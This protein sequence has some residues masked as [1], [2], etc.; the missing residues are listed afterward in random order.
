ME[1]VN[2]SNMAGL[3]GFNQL[4]DYCFDRNGVI[5]CVWVHVYEVNFSKVFYSK[6]LDEG[7]TWTTAE[8][9]SLNTAKRISEPHIVCDTNNHLHLCYDFDTGN[10]NE[11]LVYY[12]T[13]NETGWSTPDIVSENMPG[14]DHNRIVMDNNNRLYC[15]WFYGLIYYRYLENDSWSDI[16]IL[17]TGS[18]ELFYLQRCVADSFENL[19]C[20]GQHID[21]E[22][23]SETRIIYFKNEAGTWSDFTTLNNA[24]SGVSDIAL[25]NTNQPHADW[26][27]YTSNTYPPNDG[28]LYSYF[29][30]MNWTTP[31]IIVEDP[32]E[33]QIIVDENNSTNIF[34]VEKTDE[35]SMLVHYFKK[36]GTWEGFI[37]DESEWYGMTPKTQKHER[38]LYTFYIKPVIDNISEIFFSKSDII[39]EVKK[40]E[41]LTLDLTV[42]PN[43]FTYMVS[44]AFKIVKPG[45]TQI[46][47][48]AING[49]LINKLLDETT[50]PGA[51]KTIWNGKDQNGKEVKPGIYLLRLQAGRK[52]M[53]R[54][55]EFIK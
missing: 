27:Q 21:F 28:T 30:G 24:I 41:G 4:P 39:S 8:D 16:N 2:V 19:H 46:N 31:E 52:V 43:P 9:V 12:K 38:E 7:M 26:Y 14:S 29:D 3:G 22:I 5:H 33:Q 54:S 40:E 44:V 36:E 42:Y 50:P 1:P 34:D 45:N 20:I 11:T 18:N 32:I 15:F 53:T 49:V 25:N 35:G 17:F 47:I 37:I 10:T 51:Y 55:V 13:L 23:S 6:S 48:Y